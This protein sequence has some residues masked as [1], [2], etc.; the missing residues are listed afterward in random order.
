MTEQPLSI[1][2]KIAALARLKK[3]LQLFSILFVICGIAIIFLLSTR[4]VA[5][6][7]LT[8]ALVV[9][10]LL[11]FRRQAKNY[12]QAVKQAM[13]EEG[14][15]PY[16]KNIT[17]QKKDGVSADVVLGSGLLPNENPK[18]LLIR[19]T[20]Q[21]FYQTMPVFLTDI[22]TDYQSYKNDRNG[23]NKPVTDFLS[24]CL[25]DIRLSRS[26]QSDYILCSKKVLPEKNRAHYYA[27]KAECQAPGML[28]ED[29]VLY[30]DTADNIP[31]IPPE[32]EKAIHR[33]NEYT[34]GDVCVQISG[35]HLRIFLSNRFLFTLHIPGQVEIT[36]K[37]LNTNPFLEMPYLL[38]VADKFVDRN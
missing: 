34:P 21:G 4:P 28:A 33:L 13:L 14:L 7:V 37:M 17:Y 31:S 15:R 32:A 11:L 18:G 26:S 22:T 9:I 20:V 5:G 2:E 1:N 36:A 8:L 29:F 24:G 16:L 10:Y 23:D 27:G 6:L 38:R 30:T 3:N 35:D 25:F 19:D 12:R